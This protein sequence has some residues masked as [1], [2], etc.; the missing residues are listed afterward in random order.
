[1][2]VKLFLPWVINGK[3]YTSWFAEDSDLKG[4]D[5]DSVSSWVIDGYEVLGLFKTIENELNDPYSTWKR[6]K[7]K[8]RLYGFEAYEFHCA[9]S[10]LGAHITIDFPR[11][12]ANIICLADI[13]LPRRLAA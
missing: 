12:A 4:D 3:L 10:Q 6:L 7:N 11:S 2:R 9:S 8:I 1:M 13:A 5:D